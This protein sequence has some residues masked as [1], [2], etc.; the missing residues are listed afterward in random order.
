MPDPLDPEDI[1]ADAHWLAQAYDPGQQLVRFVGMT[2]EDYRAA[3]FLDDRMFDRQRDV[4]VLPWADVAEA[5][6][7]ENDARW[8]FH[9]GH[10]GS[11]MVARMLGEIPGVLSVR[12]PRILRDLAGLPRELAEAMAPTVAALCSRK[13]EDQG[14]ALVK[15]TSFVSEIAPTLVGPKTSAIFIVASA[16]SY[17]LTILAG[18]N[19]VKELHALHDYRAKRMAGRVSPMADAA[20]SDAHRAAM[21]WACEMT[22]LEAAAD[23]MPGSPIL[24]LDFD[25]FLADPAERLAGAAQ[26]CG[27]DLAAADAEAI[28]SGPLMKRYSKALEYQYSPALRRELQAEA[29]Q[30]HGR[31]IQAALNMLEEASK[32]SPLL[33]RALAR[34]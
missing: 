25:H 17:M 18:E 19:S 30:R 14:H 6:D 29:Q 12:E 23:A 27:F 4:R 13:F 9:I 10:V 7:G 3:A 2:A 22:S 21:A 28:A 16:T 20:N 26:H 24:W 34:R 33:E 11:T 15:A 31:D 5:A 1:A 8:I 32:S